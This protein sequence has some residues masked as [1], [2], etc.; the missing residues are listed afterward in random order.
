MRNFQFQ[1]IK[2]QKRIVDCD[3]GLTLKRQLRHLK[4]WQAETS[5]PHFNNGLFPLSSQE[6]LIKVA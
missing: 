1:E 4:S 6:H 2:W 5:A 3:S